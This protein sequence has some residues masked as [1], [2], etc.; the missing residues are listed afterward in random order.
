MTYLFQIVLYQGDIR[1]LGT[2]T[3][4]QSDLNLTYKHG[5]FSINC[6]DYVKRSEYR[7]TTRPTSIFAYLAVTALFSNVA[8]QLGSCRNELDDH[9]GQERHA[10]CP[11][12]ICKFLVKLLS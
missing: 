9:Y 6:K 7:P 3:H 1:Q 12:H 4:H 11:K 10:A 5:I 8:G 2:V